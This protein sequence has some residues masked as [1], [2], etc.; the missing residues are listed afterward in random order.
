LR[1]SPSAR[2]PV[3]SVA[4]GIYV[5][6]AGPWARFWGLLRRA[7]VAAYEDGCF[8]IAKGAAYSAL[9]SFF[10]VLTSLTAIL[11]RANAEA[12][13]RVL[14]EFLFEVVPP[15]SE[16]LVKFNFTVRGQRPISL[17][18]IATVIS[19][20]AASGA[21]MSLMEGFQAAYRLPSGRPFL[22]Q[23]A[24]AAFLVI[25]A[26]VPTVG[27]SL[28]I[29]FGAKA[30]AILAELS[31]LAPDGN[32]RGGVAILDKLARY[33]IAL[34][35]TVLVTG[36]LYYFGPNRAMKMR[37]VWPG[38]FLATALWLLATLGFAWYVRNIA[39][40]N[41]LY[42]SIG[43]VIVLL[44]WMYLLAAITLFGCEFNAER[45]RLMRKSW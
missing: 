10:P 13:S 42:G 22:K 33:V 8:G 5:V 17:L 40:Y 6:E 41:V 2:N 45:E 36:L 25:I 31:G 15:G 1:D 35:T 26:S 11:V 23:R 21:M 7:F 38:A 12:V 29:L 24:V 9:L 19:V 20:W 3:R 44:V 14:S 37:T 27:A 39:N 30:E 18:V 43:A 28:L 4:P 32:I 16:E 34:G